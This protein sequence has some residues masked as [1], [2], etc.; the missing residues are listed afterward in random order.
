MEVAV[1]TALS[2]LAFIL[3]STRSSTI[4]AL[5]IPSANDTN[6]A[7]AVIATSYEIANVA[8]QFLVGDTY[9]PLN[10]GPAMAIPSLYYTTLISQV[11]TLSAL[12]NPTAST[13]EATVQSLGPYK[14][15]ESFKAGYD[16]LKSAGL[17]DTPQAF[18]NSD[19]NFGAM[20]LGIRGYRIKL[21]N[22]SEWSDPLS[23]LSNSLVQEQCNDDT[24]DAA[25]LNHKVFV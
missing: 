14:S 5:S 4:A 20:G 11:A 9:Y 10:P 3:L 24:M 21:V 16:E 1:T 18:D 15:L 22:V 2:A 8:R 25:I 6:R 12:E 13:I 7:A 19:E 23:S 17:I